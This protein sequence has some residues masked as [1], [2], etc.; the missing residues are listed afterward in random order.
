MLEARLSASEDAREKLVA[1]FEASKMRCDRYHCGFHFWKAK[2]VRYLAE[3]SFVPYLRDLLWAHGFH[4]GFEN[5][6]HLLI[7]QERYGIDL[8]T[9]AS[10]YLSLLAIAINEMVDAGRELIPDAIKVNPYGHQP[11]PLLPPEPLGPEDDPS[12]ND[13]DVASSWE[14]V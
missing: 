13:D 10:D 7:N 6:W 12:D 8:A 1:D 9:V 3:L 14:E 2:V 4:W 11:T 5:C